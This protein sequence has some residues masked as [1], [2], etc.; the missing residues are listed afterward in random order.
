[1]YGTMI[2]RHPIIIIQRFSG[3]S[4]HSNRKERLPFFTWVDN[5]TKLIGE[6]LAATGNI[7]PDHHFDGME[8]DTVLF[9]T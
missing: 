2:Y 6:G 4:K 8:L 5:R 1:M 9:P 3:Y 7:Q